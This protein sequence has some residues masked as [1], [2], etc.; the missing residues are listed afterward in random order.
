MNVSYEVRVELDAGLATA[1]QSYMRDTHIPDILATGC[2]TQARFDQVSPTQFR[3]SYQ[4]PQAGLDRYLAEHAA[5]FR[6]DFLQHFPTGVSVQRE[7][8]R[9]VA[10]WP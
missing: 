1:F 5:H 7:V 4:G 6:E 2:F 9:G 8:W 10:S 3:T